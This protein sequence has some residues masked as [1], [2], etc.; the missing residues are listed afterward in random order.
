MAKNPKDADPTRAW[1]EIGK[2][3]LAAY[4]ATFEATGYVIGGTAWDLTSTKRIGRDQ[5]DLV[6]VDEA[7]QYSLAPTI[8][9]SMAGSRLLLLGDPQQLPQVSQG[10]HP[11]PVDGSAL[12]WLLDGEPVMPAHLGYFLE[13]TW[14]MHPALTDKVS[15]LSY[16][17]ALRSKEA[18]TTARSLAGIEPG[19]HVV[20]VEHRDNTT[21]SVEEA[22]AVARLV[23]D[24]VGRDWVDPDEGGGPSGSGVARPLT[25]ADIRVV[26]PYNAQ[27][28][29]IREVLESAGH[30]DV[31]VAS[32]DKFQ[33]QEAAVIIMSMAASAAVDVSRGLGFL[34]SR[35]R[36]NV[37]ISRGKW[38]AYVVR[39]DILT[40]FSPRT[41]GELVALGAFIGLCEPDLTSSD[42]EHA[43]AASG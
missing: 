1:T 17:G 28:A 8:A 30:G 43:A 24:L 6:V 11:E 40:D 13:T 5:L 3:D 25:T 7:G 39:S 2:D 12:G 16:A 33:G 9:C 26:T 36:L 32:V 22:E 27:V 31:A 18:R 10:T 23:A 42:R 19:L 38:A 34:L 15:T 21:E 29:R 37:A 14:R 41:P 20:R 35:N 4:T